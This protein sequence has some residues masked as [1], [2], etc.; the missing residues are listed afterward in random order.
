M[1]RKPIHLLS[2]G[3]VLA[4]DLFMGKKRIFNKGTVLTLYDY[5][6][7]INY[8]FTY[9]HVLENP[10]KT[11]HHE[12]KAVKLPERDSQ[13]LFEELYCQFMESSTIKGRYCKILDGEEERHSIEELFRQLLDHPFIPT[14]LTALKTW[15]FYSFSHSMDVFILGTQWLKQLDV[16]DSLMEIATGLLLHDIGK[17]KI[18]QQILQKPGKLSKKEFDI[19]KTHVL[20]GEQLLKYAGFSQII[21]EMALYHHKTLDYTGYPEEGKPEKTLRVEIKVLTI[22]DV[23][24]ALT[25]ERP[26][27]KAFTMEKALEIMHRDQKKFE[28]D[29]FHKFY[30]FIRLQDNRSPSFLL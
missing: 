19:V 21:R 29:L 16:S 26:Y 12:D 7:L 24:S 9:I 18:P 25:L 20:H 15:D 14:M 8:G 3:D 22:I 28:P 2:V 1:E 27:R 11:L 17:M 30:S 13:S 6:T 5:L 4:E 10:K 23:F